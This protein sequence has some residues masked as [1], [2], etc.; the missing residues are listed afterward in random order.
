MCDYD[1]LCNASNT[2]IASAIPLTP[3][4]NQPLLLAVLLL[5]LLLFVADVRNI[6]SF[7]IASYV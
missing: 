4:C 7:D 5:V 1:E 2:E 3:H 6:S